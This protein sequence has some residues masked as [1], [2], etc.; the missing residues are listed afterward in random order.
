MCYSAVTWADYRK[1]VRGDSLEGYWR[2]AFGRRHAVIAATSFDEHV[3]VH[4]VEGR[5]LAP[6]EQPQSTE[7]Q[8]KP[9]DWREMLLACR[10]A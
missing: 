2:T 5:E 7:L 3:D 10:D 4:R 6:D 8:F 1:Y 9:K